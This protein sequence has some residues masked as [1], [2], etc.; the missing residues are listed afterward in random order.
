MVGVFYL[1]LINSAY[2]WFL[3]FHTRFRLAAET[4]FQF[5]I[6]GLDLSGVPQPGPAADHP[7]LEK[8]LGS[9]YFPSSSTFKSPGRAGGDPA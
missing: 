8:F 9:L 1:F 6:F 3:Y 5:R 7:A 4:F 2:I